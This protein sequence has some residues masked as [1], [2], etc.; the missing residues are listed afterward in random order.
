MS[1]SSVGKRLFDL[2]LATLALVVL[3]PALAVAALAI[4]FFDGRPV[5]FHQPRLGRGRRPFDL[6]KLRTMKG[7]VVT[8]SGRLLRECGLDELPQLVHVLR[9]EMSLVGPRPL[10]AADVR[11]LGWDHPR[12]DIRWQIRPGL[13]G[14]GQLR[15][16]G[17][18]H[19]A[20][21]FLYDRR[22]AEQADW[23]R[24]VLLLVASVFVAAVGKE[25]G[26]RWLKRGQ[27][28]RRRKERDR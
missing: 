28:L 16:R 19:P 8:R 5:C 20:V 25:R 6:W 17:R 13:T 14:P 1:S 21:T 10:T 23:K 24:D 9:G 15:L 12:Y 26:R 27:P 7:S 11:R 22:Y 4:W 18:C 3:S 2:A